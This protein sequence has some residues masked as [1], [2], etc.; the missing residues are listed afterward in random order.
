VAYL[1]EVENVYDILMGIRIKGPDG[2]T[3]AAGYPLVRKTKV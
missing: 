2:T 1:N 3:R